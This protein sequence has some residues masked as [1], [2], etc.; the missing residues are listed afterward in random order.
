MKRLSA[1]DSADARVK[2]GHRQATYKNE[3]PCES[4]GLRFSEGCRQLLNAA[5]CSSCEAL[6]S[7]IDQIEAKKV[8]RRLTRKAKA[9]DNLASVL[10]TARNESKA[11]AADLG[12]VSNVL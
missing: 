11:K 10:T 2:V 3:G 1:D 5:G 4:G 7:Q 12:A 6:N 9:G 8:Q